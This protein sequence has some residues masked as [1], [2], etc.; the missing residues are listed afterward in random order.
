MTLRA[1]AQEPTL[2]FSLLKGVSYRRRL[3]VVTIL[4]AVG[5]LLQVLFLS[6]W[7]GVPFLLAAVICSWVVGFDNRLDKR[8]LRHDVAWETAPFDR[9][10]TILRLDRAGRRWDFSLLDISNLTGCGIFLAALTGAALLAILAAAEAG[11]SAAMIVGGDLVL[12]ILAQW[13]SG[14]R[15]G[16]RQADLVIK[17][18]HDLAVMRT[19]RAEVEKEG[20]LRVQL[21]MGGKT[22]DRA[23]TDL[24]L[25]IHYPEAPAHFLGVQAQIVLN[26]VQGRPYPY[27]YAV[28]LARE[29]HGLFAA[30]KRVQLPGGVIREKKSQGDVEVSI[31]RQQTTKTSGYHT[32]PDVSCRILRT[33][34]EIARQTQTV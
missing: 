27:F 23:P 9:V 28:V 32:K 6:F 12:L 7:A 14:M 3:L 29:G 1:E 19:M 33:A 5:L 20:E 21:R 34:L 2:Q 16:H 18:E 31:I 24:K 17:A 30:A 13:F 22:D 11:L 26:R 15:A 10:E 4:A 8:R 25:S